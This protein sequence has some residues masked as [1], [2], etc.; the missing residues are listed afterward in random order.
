MKIRTYRGQKTL[1]K[2]DEICPLTIPYLLFTILMQTPSLVKIHWHLQKL[3]GNENTDG[4]TVPWYHN[5]PPL[6][7]GGVWKYIDFS[8]KSKPIMSLFQA[9]KLRQT[10]TRF[11]IPHFDSLFSCDYQPNS[12]VTNSSLLTL[13]N[14]KS[15]FKHISL[16]LSYAYK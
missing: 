11:S 10:A 9:V 14:L 3:S 1:A 13:I 15:A 6:S 7:C 4:R 5:T 12:Y 8:L 16:I 2:I